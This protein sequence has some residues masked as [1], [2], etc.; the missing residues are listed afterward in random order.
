MDTSCQDSGPPGT[1]EA[2]DTLISR[3]ADSA[4]NCSAVPDNV[5][6]EMAL[7]GVLDAPLE[8]GVSLWRNVS[9]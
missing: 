8:N 2:A 3:I 6:S 9:K 1:H 5:S 7:S 4:F